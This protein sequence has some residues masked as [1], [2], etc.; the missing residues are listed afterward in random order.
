MPKIPLT[1]LLLFALSNMYAQ[2]KKQYTIHGEI[3][4]APD[5]TVMYMMAIPPETFD[6]CIV[7]GERFSFTGTLLQP[8]EAIVWPGPVSRMSDKRARLQYWIDEQ[9]VH[10][11]GAMTD[12]AAATIKAGHAEEDYLNYIKGL[13]DSND[14]S[15]MAYLLGYARKH[16]DSYKV[17]QELFYRRE[18]FSLEAMKVIY[19]GYSRR[20]KQSIF[21]ESMGQYL[22]TVTQLAPGKP[23]AAFTLPDMDNKPTTLADF[24]GKYVLLNFWASNCGPCRR[25]NPLLNE[26]Y[27]KYRNNN[28][29]ILGVGLD[30]YNTFAAAIRKDHVE[31][32]NTYDP[33]PLSSKMMAMYNISAIPYMLLLDPQGKILLMNPGI[34]KKDQGYIITDDKGN[35][36]GNIEDILKG[37]HGKPALQG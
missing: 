10:I 27:E 37:N 8:A 34:E 19:D 16:P 18:S 12:F 33:S 23:A 11:S 21:G 25:K 9:P 29:V 15:Q 31:W 6:S 4:G 14:S 20:I 2:Q 26:V 22:A 17:A 3:K 13:P 5:G 7:K 1:L 24:K 35:I 32:P 30:Q 28:F 36:Y